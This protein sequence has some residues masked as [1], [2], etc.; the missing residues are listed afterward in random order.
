MNWGYNISEDEAK[1]E[2]AGNLFSSSPDDM[3]MMQER[4]LAT[5]GSSTNQEDVERAIELAQRTAETMIAQGYPDEEI[6]RAV[7]QLP[8]SPDHVQT[9]LYAAQQSLDAQ[10]FNVFDDRNQQ[11]DQQAMGMLAALGVCGGQ[12]CSPGLLGQLSPLQT[13]NLVEERGRGLFA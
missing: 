4:A 3:E 9:A 5:V 13:P 10:K 6:Q 8:I 11:Q 2:S 7:A 1:R 12:E